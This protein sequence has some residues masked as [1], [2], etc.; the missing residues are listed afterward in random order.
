MSSPRQG[1]RRDLGVTTMT[2]SASKYIEKLQE[3]IR[4]LKE[5]NDKLKQIIE[6]LNSNT[7]FPLNR[8]M[9]KKL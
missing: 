5:N 3:E 1:I 6:L 2:S 4:V 8:N 7:D 9:W